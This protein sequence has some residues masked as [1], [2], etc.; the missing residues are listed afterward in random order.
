MSSAAWFDEEEQQ[1]RQTRTKEREPIDEIDLETTALARVAP[2]SGDDTA[3]L[4]ALARS[5]GPRD[6]RA[7]LAGAREIG[8]RLGAILDPKGEGTAAYYRWKARNRDG[9]EAVI[10]GPTVGMMDELAGLW[11]GL[12]YSV[13]VISQRG[14]T[15]TL[16]GRVLDL[17]RIV[18]H[19]RDYRGWLRPAPARF[20]GE[21]R[22][23]WETMQLQAAESKAVRGVLEHIVPSILV[24]TAM[25]AARDAAATAR[26]GGRT[27]D[28]G[29]ARSLS[30]LDKVGLG[31]VEQ[32]SRWVGRPPAQ[33]TAIDLGELR[34]VYARAKRGELPAD[35]LRVEAAQREAARRAEEPESTAQ[36]TD[37]LAGLGLAAPA[38]PEPPPAALPPADPDRTRLRV[39]LQAAWERLGA[40]DPSGATRVRESMGV[41]RWDPERAPLERLEE[42]L[43]AIDAECLRLREAQAWLN[44]ITEASATMSSAEYGA[45]CEASGWDPSV[46]PTARASIELLRALRDALVCG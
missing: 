20:Q 26:L 30:A 14:E 7:I 43:V 38:T 2:D 8:A 42:M 16:R 11:G 35:A 41:R 36:S 31:D 24:K 32:L 22:G 44:E 21:E 9:S 10:E 28:E 6:M 25:E 46:A 5:T 13:R 29:V 27:L 12:V 15:V 1:Q 17:Q 39:A 18:A 19:E 37:R 34:D 23:R 40:L 4:A 45:A 33:W 3:A